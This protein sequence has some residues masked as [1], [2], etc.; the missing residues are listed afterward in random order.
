MRVPVKARHG[1]PPPPRT[2]GRFRVG[3]LVDLKG[4]IVRKRVFR[5]FS[6]GVGSGVPFVPVFGVSPWFGPLLVRIWGRLGC[7][8]RLRGPVAGL[9]CACSQAGA[10]DRTPGKLRARAGVLGVGGGCAEAGNRTMHSR[11][12]LLGS[13]SGGR[14]QAPGK[15][16][17]E[18]RRR[19]PM[20]GRG[21]MDRVGVCEFFVSGWLRASRIPY[22]IARRSLFAQE[23][24]PFRV[25]LARARLEGAR[26]NAKKCRA[27]A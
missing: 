13:G 16:K 18:R 27:R 26:G 6:G 4:E 20:R 2:P 21:C 1:R 19:A 24:I 3:V 15:E 7:W 22:G 23:R 11:P 17:C 8:R 12:R 9:S 25:R 10:K 14:K 5:R